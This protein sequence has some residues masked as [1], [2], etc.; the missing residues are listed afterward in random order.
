[1]FGLSWQK[2][3]STTKNNDISPNS[4]NA[5]P[6]IGSLDLS[7]F[8][9]PGLEEELDPN[10]EF[11]DADLV[12]P[13]L[14]G[15]LQALSGSSTPSSKI[16]TQKQFQA[17]LPPSTATLKL[18]IET[19]NSLA[20]ET[21]VEAVLTEDDFKDPTLLKELH[22]LGSQSDEHVNQKDF[23]NVAANSDSAGDAL[24]SK[25]L[26]LE[27]KEQKELKSLRVDTESIKKDFIG[28]QTSTNKS[29]YIVSD[30]IHS[31]SLNENNELALDDKL[32][33]DDPEKL[34]N[35]IQQEKLEAVRK[36]RAGD[37]AG[38]LESIRVYKRL[39]ARRVEIL[40]PTISQ[41]SFEKI[42]K[43]LV[44]STNDIKMGT[45]A[46][47]ENRAFGA[48]SEIQ[49]GNLNEGLQGQNP[50]IIKIKQLQKQYK[51]AAIQYKDL[52][53]IPKA[54]EMLSTSQVL[55]K[56]FRVLEKGGHLPEGWLMPTE[57]DLPEEIHLES[58]SPSPTPKRSSHNIDTPVP[59]SSRIDNP[60][61]NMPS[62]AELEAP[63]STMSIIEQYERLLA[64]LRDQ[65]TS[66]SNIISEFQKDGDKKNVAL[67]TNYKKEFSCDL[68]SLSSYRIHGKDIP[69][70]HFQQIQYSAKN[71]C[72][73]L[74]END[75][76]VCIDR[77]INLGNKEVSGRDVEAY[78]SWDIGW[79]TD[80]T[81]TA[82]IGKGDTSVAKKG[83]DPEFNFRKILMIDR[84]ARPFQRHLERKKATFEVFH[85]R[86]FLRKAISLGKVQ[87]K[88]DQLLRKPEIH[89]IIELS[90][91]GR[92][93]TGG[94][95]EVRLRLRRPIL[96]DES[97]TKILKW[98]II[99]EF[100][101]SNSAL[102]NLRSPASLNLPKSTATNSVMNS[103][104]GPK[105]MDH[106]SRMNQQQKTV[107]NPI[108]PNAESNTPKSIV[109]DS[110][111][112]I[113][114]ESGSRAQTQ[115]GINSPTSNRTEVI[116][117]IR[118]PDTM[119]KTAINSASQKQEELE[120]AEE[121]LNNV[122]NIVS[123]LV[124]EHEINLA[125]NLISSLKSQRKPIPEDLTDRKQAL[126]I[127]MNLLIIQVQ[128]GQLTMENYLNQVRASIIQFKKLA[129]V[130]KQA[131]KIEEAKRA[132]GRSKIMDGEVKEAEEAIANG[133]YGDE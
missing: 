2:A 59:I 19:L 105:D 25:S 100:R 99:D 32:K 18:D 118:P 39:E 68:D 92:R 16:R 107:Q 97:V 46:N 120:R 38:A 8:H 6:R 116:S 117:E 3:E 50:L 69:A 34:I 9:I 30:K 62:L 31:L 87:L 15:E 54:K 44:N 113:S 90:E 103:E 26:S 82:S 109:K 72:Y 126:E 78:V 132:L 70:Y 35:F 55:L 53:N 37:K 64:H 124:L 101:T 133:A 119:T 84:N 79:P 7:D 24:I 95:I 61:I 29:E 75:L 104:S 60:V 58:Q 5:I 85:Y 121:E 111:S 57:P 96:R 76:E 4:K 73:E 48:N 43:G 49:E 42:P 33:I 63:L 102:A 114:T 94:K 40:G 21:E 67:F 27:A 14:L 28:S 65:I 122:D 110:L 115:A 10:V 11:S 88:L 17:E 91:G 41:S 129:L 22:R 45:A 128:T 123:N 12:D 51:N 106:L 86:G 131:G 36:K 20:G 71:C 80:G 112:Y 108:K 23:Q 81:S 127:K 98:V 74:G 47:V 66:C 125:N 1:M 56:S 83:M 13:D 77:G 52:N 93:S 130:F 89:E